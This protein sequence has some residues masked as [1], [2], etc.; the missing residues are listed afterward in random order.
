MK[1]VHAFGRTYDLFHDGTSPTG[2]EVA[3]RFEIDRNY[4]QNGKL[5]FVSGLPLTPAQVKKVQS[6]LELGINR[7]EI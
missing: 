6:G 4:R 2:F 7:K 1:L 5:H 3:T